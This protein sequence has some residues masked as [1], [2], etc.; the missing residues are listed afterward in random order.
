[1]KPVWA[2]LQLPVVPLALPL[3]EFW[4][5][6]QQHIRH[7]RIEN[8]RATSERAMEEQRAKQATLQTYLDQMDMLLLAPSNSRHTSR[9]HTI[10]LQM[11]SFMWWAM[12]G[13]N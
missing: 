10:F 9:V 5:T 2:W 6:M 7:Q 4:L 11:Q 1:V 3:I 13:S 12:L 8:Q